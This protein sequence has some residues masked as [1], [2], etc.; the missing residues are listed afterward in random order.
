M[1]PTNAA[2]I[3]IGGLGAG[4]ATVATGAS[5][6]AGRVVHQTA[7]VTIAIATPSAPHARLRAGRRC[8][9]SATVGRASIA[10][11]A[12]ARFFRRELKEWEGRRVS[13]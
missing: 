7:P 4:I 13:R 8:G 9:V 10:R 11:A 2:S 6:T 12:F 1:L 3:G 5:G